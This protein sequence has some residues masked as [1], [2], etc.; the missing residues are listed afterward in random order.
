MSWSCQFLQIPDS[1]SC[2]VLWV[3]QR[4]L[5]GTSADTLW[6]LNLHRCHHNP[7]EPH[8]QVWGSKHYVWGISCLW[9]CRWLAAA[10]PVSHCPTDSIC[11]SWGNLHHSG[12]LF[13]GGHRGI[14]DTP[15][16]AHSSQR[17]AFWSHGFVLGVTIFAQ[18]LKKKK[19]CFQVQRQLRQK[20]V[21]PT[22][23]PNW[24]HITSCLKPQFV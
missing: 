24:C 22:S 17:K 15:R 10:G 6:E 8:V 23:R 19:R 21:I 3:W 20:S 2:S 11:P 13:P 16:T 12:N 14:M 7:T 5:K 1:V 4:L 9:P 18:T